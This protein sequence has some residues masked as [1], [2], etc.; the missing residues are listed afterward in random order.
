MSPSVY[1][2]LQCLNLWMRI[3]HILAEREKR[4][5]EREAEKIGYDVGILVKWPFYVVLI[6]SWEDNYGV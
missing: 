4:R 5:L 3:P 2:H 6:Y 1:V